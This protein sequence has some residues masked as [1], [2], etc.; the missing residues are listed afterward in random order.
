[1][2]SKQR[3]FLDFVLKQYVDSG[4]EEL[5]DAKLPELLTLKY[6]AISDA[7]RQLGDIQTIRNTFI[8]FQIYLYEV[9]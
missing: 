2:E 6:K 8:G 7:K 1:F 5:D 4:V 9:A 3:I